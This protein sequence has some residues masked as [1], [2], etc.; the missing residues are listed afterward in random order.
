MPHLFRDFIAWTLGG[1]GALFALY[2]WALRMFKRATDL[3]CGYGWSFD[4]T[5]D[6]A[7]NMRPHLDVR[8]CS[9]SRT[10]RLA[11]IS[12]EL[13]GVQHWCDNTSLWGMDLK[14]GSIEFFNAIAP[15]PRIDSLKACTC[16]AVRLRFQDNHEILCHGPG[17]PEGKWHH[18]ARRFRSWLDRASIAQGD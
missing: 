13:G 9:Q 6:N 8:N 15:I 14:P 7:R 4:G 11:N 17:Q 3:D 16:L 18:K 12:Y 10:Y 2:R 1:G 5:I